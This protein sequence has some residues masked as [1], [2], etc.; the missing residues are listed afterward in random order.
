MMHGGALASSIDQALY[1]YRKDSI[2]KNKLFIQID[3]I[4]IRYLTSMKVII[5][6]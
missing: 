3:D 4:D 1:L 6:Q 5:N 2:E